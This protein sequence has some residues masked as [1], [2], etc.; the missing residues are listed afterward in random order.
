MIRLFAGIALPED[1]RTRLEMIC[2]GVR[3]ARWTAPENL[4][5]T[6]RF[7]GEVPEPAVEDIVPALDRIAF[8]P[9]DLFLDGVGHFETRGRVRTL[10]AG[11]AGEPALAELQSRI[12]AALRRTGCAPETRNF[13]PHVTLARL[14]GARPDA[15]Q[16]WI[17]ANS[18]FRAGP[19]RVG[20]FVLFE[21]RL[22]G[23]GPAYFPIAEFP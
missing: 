17:A 13:K 11:L 14:K 20:E 22:G 6:L 5:L 23:E 12:E 18:L 16:G 4:H 15:V 7:I 19:F 3:D 10:W 8:D 21:S 9:F 1:I 2:A